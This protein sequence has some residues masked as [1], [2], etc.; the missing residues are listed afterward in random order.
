MCIFFYFFLWT[1]YE[2]HLP[3][4]IGKKRNNALNPSPVLSFHL[5]I[6]FWINCLLL[7]QLVRLA[8]VILFLR[9]NSILVAPENE[10]VKVLLVQALFFLVRITQLPKLLGCRISSYY[11]V[12]E[13]MCRYS[14]HLFLHLEKF[15]FRI[16]KLIHVFK[17]E[18]YIKLLYKLIN[19]KKSC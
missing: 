15:Y 8:A 6:Y 9:T 2:H 4:K 1:A 12:I 3:I 14:E 5:F 13:R 11:L 17:N 7:H 16:R 10:L 18:N 19:Y